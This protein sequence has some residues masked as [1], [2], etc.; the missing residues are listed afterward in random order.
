MLIRISKPEVKGF[1][2]G[3]LDAETGKQYRS[4]M[5]EAVV[6]RACAGYPLAMRI[7]HAG[8]AV[9]DRIERSL[10]PVGL[11]LA[12]MGV[13]RHL[14]AGDPI[15]LG[16]LAERLSCVRSNVTQ[17]VDRLEADGL[18]RRLPDPND[19]RSVLAAI[20]DEGRRSYE[21]GARAQA[22]AEEEILGTL[23]AED[24]ERLARLLERLDAHE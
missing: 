22:A 4:G 9:G 6:E 16:Q 13:L 10:E 20:T 19:R 1:L 23:S 24:Q 5:N 3:A 15:P 14:A 17:L 12:K 8:S 11:S 21:A 18:V 7:L 2:S